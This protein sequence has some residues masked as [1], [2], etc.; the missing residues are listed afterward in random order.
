[1]VLPGQL[2]CVQ[3]TRTQVGGGDV[4]LVAKLNRSVVRQEAYVYGHGIPRACN[5]QSLALLRIIV[6]FMWNLV[7]L[8]DIRTMNGPRLRSSLA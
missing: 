8:R 7:Q 1:M 6:S 4:A 2:E 5:R 3:G